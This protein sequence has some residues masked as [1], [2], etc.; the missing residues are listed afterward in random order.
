MRVSISGTGGFEK[1]MK[2]LLRVTKDTSG[3]KQAAN[4]GVSMLK[5]AT[6][7]RSG[8]TADSWDSEVTSTK[9]GVD[10]DFTNSART[11]T[12][13]IPIVVLIK[14]GHGT[15]TGGYVPAN[16]FITPVLD[17]VV[18]SVSREVERKLK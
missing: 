4:E 2:S 12:G 18:K 8:T 5:E 14:N 16:D 11:K 6:P 1:E 7:V 10:I 3:L 17:K 15:G 9:E 13:N